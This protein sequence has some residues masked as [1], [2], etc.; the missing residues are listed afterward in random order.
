MTRPI[1]AVTVGAMK[2]TYGRL[3][4]PGSLYTHIAIAIAATS[5]KM[6]SECCNHTDK[7]T[8]NTINDIAI[9]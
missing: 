6:I 7:L 5:G 3:I 8:I 2:I 1:A 4:H 9:T